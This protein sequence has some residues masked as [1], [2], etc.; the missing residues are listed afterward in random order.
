MTFDLLHF[1]L[2]VSLVVA[3]LSYLTKGSN[4][5]EYYEQLSAFK[6]ERPLNTNLALN[7][8]LRVHVEVSAK[9]DPEY[10]KLVMEDLFLVLRSVTPGL[11]DEECAEV[12]SAMPEHLKIK[13]ADHAP[14]P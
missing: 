3:I 6:T 9:S 13:D 7:L 2:L 4:R 1:L 14:K 10:P 12:W 8:P 11:T 5:N